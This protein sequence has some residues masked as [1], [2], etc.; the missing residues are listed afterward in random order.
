MEYSDVG[1]VC[2]DEMPV[3]KGRR[4]MKTVA[5]WLVAVAL[6]GGLSLVAGPADHIGFTQVNLNGATHLHIPGDA[7]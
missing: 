4:N 7:R 2:E 5:A 1:S 6:V 3:G